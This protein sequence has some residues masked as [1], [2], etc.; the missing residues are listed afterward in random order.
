MDETRLMYSKEL[1]EVALY[2]ET[3]I[4]NEIPSKELTPEHFVLAML[5]TKNCHAHMILESYLMNNNIVSLREL[6]ANALTACNNEIS[7]LTNDIIEIP[8]SKE[9]NKL[10]EDA[11]NE[12]EIT[13]SKI[14]GT[15]HF[16]LALLNPE[17]NL[18]SGK[19][20]KSAG[21]DYNNILSKCQ[22]ETKNRHTKK[23][24]NKNNNNMN[25]P[26]KSEVNIKSVSPKDNFIKQYTINLNQ[27]V[28]DGKVDKTIGREKELKIIMQVLSRRRKNNVVLVGKGGVGKTSIV[29]G[30]AKLINEHKVPSVLDGKELLLLNIM[31]MVSGTSLRGM[32]EERVKGLFDELENNDKYILVIDDMQMVLKNGNKD[33]DTDISDK[34]GKILE[35]GNVR[36]IGTLPFKEYRNCVENNTQLSRKLQKIVIEP[37][38]VSETIQIIKENKKFYEDYHNTIYRDEIIKK[39]VELSEKYINDRCLPD[40]AIDVIDL[41]GAGLCL[42]KTEPEMITST[43]IRLHEIANEKKKYMNNGEWELV[44]DLNKEEKTLNRK[45]TD[46]KREQ[47]KDNKNIVPVTENDIAKVISDITGVPVTKLSSNEK[48]KIAHIDNILKESIIG[49][50]EAVEAICK[51]IKRNKV[52]LGDKTKTMS[53]ILMMGPSGCGKTLIAKKLAEEIFGDEK[54]LIRIDMSE[55]SEKNSVSKL[56]GASPGYVGYEN[57]GQL[58]EAIKNKQ[59]CVLL[60]DEIEKADQEVYNLFLQLFDDGRLTD[61]SGQL[62]NFKNVIVLMTSNIGAKQASEFGKSIGFTTNV[63]NNK[64]AIIEKEMKSKFTPE[65]L[66]RIDQIVYFNSLTDDN[67]KGITEL[68]IKKFSNR[69]KQAGYNITYT[70]KVVDFIYQKAVKQKEYGARPIIRFVQN[71][72]E[73]KLTDVILLGDYE[74]G[75][76]F[77]FDFENELIIS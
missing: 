36:V 25:I 51:V 65:F 23:P 57:G 13:K 28:K 43:R 59:H 7:G 1:D 3:S 49:Q 47:K 68:E 77:N 42:T 46:Y 22:S 55:Y 12:K 39:A 54:S 60:L 16:L 53:N 9:M 69:V 76:T 10:M 50:D 11:E 37:N 62:V 18:N 29:Y 30:L 40:S 8:F 64:K 74:N 24:K 66:N 14:L 34:I 75:H 45:L 31:S 63:S 26:S 32:F 20:F 44:E 56:T 19:I 35:D 2:M 48:T 15:E 41:A 58:T 61:S 71:E 6:F 67:L 17:L 27:I 38:N 52:G 21:I 72:L 73:D 5:D 4:L 33:R 70:P